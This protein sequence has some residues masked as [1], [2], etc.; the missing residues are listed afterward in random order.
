M[1][2]FVL[3]DTMQ[4]MSIQ[5]IKDLLKT[6]PD[7][8]KVTV[9]GWVRTKRDSKNLVFVQINDGSCFSSIQVTFDRDANA[10]NPSMSAIESELK[11]RQRLLI[12]LLVSLYSTNIFHRTLVM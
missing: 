8:R 6:S 2:S 3:S 10:D 4:G 9:Y 1:S 11:R 12:Q 5:L 7:G